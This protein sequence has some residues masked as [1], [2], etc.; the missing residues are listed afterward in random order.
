M[1]TKVV[2]AQLIAFLVVALV[3]ILFVGAK[4]ARLDTMFGVGLYRVRIA[5]ADS[6][7]IFPNAEVTYRGVPVGRVGDIE[8]QRSGIAV[9]LDLDASGPRI[10]A[11]AVPVIANRSA[12]G[13]Q[14]VDLQPISD[15]GPYLEDGATLT[16][17]RTPVP[18]DHVLASVDTF[19]RS[20]PLDDL[21]TVVTELGIALDGRGE[22]LGRLADSLSALTKD[23]VEHL[24]QTIELL[25]RSNVVLATQAEQAGAI[26]GFADALD[27]VT[28]V[29]ADH[30]ADVRLLAANGTPAMTELES[31]VA[32]S[33]PELTTALHNL[34]LFGDKLAPQAVALSPLLLT[35]PGVAAAASTIAPGD[36][37]VHQAISLEVGNPPSCTVGYEGT[38]E[39]VAQLQALDPSFDPTLAD[40][41]LNRTASC[42]V[43]VGSETGVRSAN[44]IGL[45]APETV[46]PWDAKPK[47]AAE[48][49]DLNPIA[50]QLAPL[51][52]VTPK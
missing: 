32:R 52:G 2:R 26:T 13:E 45:T 37:S 41:P 11:D 46:Q 34:A 44:R 22:A 6:A 47:R 29:L 8:L 12:I 24:P 20:V 14:Y 31:L 3:G 30:D 51:L 36:R 15:D 17:A 1:T 28:A 42:E 10:P 39:I 18:L 43:P 33:G 19:V 38:Q 23:G 4:Y 48:A 9:R 40:F 5:M 50:T 25:R 7:G 35:L 21:T 49:L 16:G 27:Q